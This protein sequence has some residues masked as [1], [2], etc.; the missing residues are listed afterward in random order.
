MTYT[1]RSTELQPFARG[2]EFG[3]RH[4]QQIQATLDG[5]ASLFS[6]LTNEGFDLAAFGAEALAGIGAHAPRLREE[7]EG[8][9]AG[10]GLSPALL[11]ALNARTEILARTKG[12]RRGECSAI[13]HIEPSGAT[14]IALQNWD[15]YD[16]F[17]DKWLVWEI[18]HADGSMTTT[19]TEFGIVGKFGIN[20]HGVGTLFTIL[21][22][23]ADGGAI[24]L[25]VHVAAR[26]VLDEGTDINQAMMVLTNG[27]YSASSSITIVST[28]A[29]FNTAVTAE[30]YPE[31]VEFVFPDEN[32]LL[33]RT[34][35]FQAEATRRADQTVRIFPDTLLRHHV[36]QRQLSRVRQPK[37][38]DILSAM[39]CGVGGD[40]AV[41]TKVNPEL[42]GTPQFVTVAT[43]ALDFQNNTLRVL[44]TGPD[45]TA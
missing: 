24:G 12:R 9:A 35:H 22:H 1:F 45:D 14:P 10:T 5:Y 32:G 26:K 13:V 41:F 28:E 27:T 42:A 4:R 7:I 8:I 23:A 17:L 37:L 29:G 34:N 39:R 44:S 33:V 2:Q 21:A 20:S 43:V 6:F 38:A 40:C 30:I 18:P 16:G 31:G 36:L 11:G 3:A 19:F 25:P 15:W